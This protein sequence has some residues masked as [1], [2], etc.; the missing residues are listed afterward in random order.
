MEARIVAVSRFKSGRFQPPEYR[1]G[2][3]FPS[4][5]LILSWAAP[6]APLYLLSPLFRGRATA[7]AWKRLVGRFSRFKSGRFQ[8]LSHGGTSMNMYEHYRDGLLDGTYRITD[9]PFELRTKD[10]CMYIFAIRYARWLE[11]AHTELKAIEH[12]LLNDILITNCEDLK[13]CHDGFFNHGGECWYYFQE[14]I[15]AREHYGT[16]PEKI[17]RRKREITC[18]KTR[19]GKR[20]GPY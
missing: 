1:E 6:P 2:R 4:L 3:G 10:R 8:P 7:P 19:M 11:M 12:F 20:Y 9:V 14:N 5:F 16:K 17:L 18:G 15:T 13:K